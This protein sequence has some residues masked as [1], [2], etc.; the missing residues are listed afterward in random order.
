M[1]RI[2]LNISGLPHQALEDAVVNSGL[3]IVLKTHRVNGETFQALIGSKVVNMAG[4]KVGDFR[5]MRRGLTL[6]INPAMIPTSSLAALLS[7]VH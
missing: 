1:V 5:Q 2:E 6:R 3:K 7:A 4:I